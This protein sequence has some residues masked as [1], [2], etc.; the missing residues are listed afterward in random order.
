MTR[1]APAQT[2]PAENAPEPDLRALHR[3]DRL[4][5]NGLVGVVVTSRDGATLRVDDFL[6]SCRVFARGIE[7]ALL[8][9][10]LRHAHRTG[11]AEVRA[12]YTR[13]AKNGKVADFYPRAGFAAV[14]A[15]DAG[16]RFRHDLRDLPEPPP[17][18]RLTARFDEDAP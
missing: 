14:S 18:V 15:D 16:A 13:T 7:Q 11:A 17:H 6:L 9:A 8:A 4:G 2:A 12:D 5:D 10:V 1:T 3:A